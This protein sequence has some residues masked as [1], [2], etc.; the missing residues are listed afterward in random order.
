M[1]NWIFTLVIN[2]L[3][4]TLLIMILSG[5]TLILKPKLAPGVICPL[6]SRQV[7]YLKKCLFLM[8]SRTK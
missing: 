1:Q 8:V 7:K 3:V 5:L 2:S 4:T 6:S